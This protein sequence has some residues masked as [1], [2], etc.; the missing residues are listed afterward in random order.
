[1]AGVEEK[2]GSFLARWSERKLEARGG[3]V[4]EDRPPDDEAEPDTP[5]ELAAASEDAPVLTDADMPPLESLGEGSDYAGF[6]SPGVTEELRRKALSKLFHSAGFNI[7]DGLD[8]YDEDFTRF[9]PLGDIITSDMRHQMEVAAKR[10]LAD[11]KSESGPEL[12]D[13]GEEQMAADEALETSQ[14]ADDEADIGEGA[15]E[16]RTDGEPV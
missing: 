12:E 7:A 5:P 9:L 4:P 8:D 16:D 11:E 6:L 3:I 15:D 2:E 1:M 10:L 14:A 13:A